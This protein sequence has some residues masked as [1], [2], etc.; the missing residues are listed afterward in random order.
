MNLDDFLDLIDQHGPKPGVWPP[1]ERESMLELLRQSP[2]AARLLDI[3]RSID[4]DLAGFE[5]VVTPGLKGRILAHAAINPP[6]NPP[7]VLE[8]FLDWLTA[9]L[10]RPVLL[11]V[12]PLALGTLLGTNLP[13]AVADNDASLDI[14]GLLLDEVYTRYE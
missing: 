1:A 3:S 8:R 6:T 7:T 2:E 11:S 4:A 14:A 13:S 9:A 12:A 5:H 10:W